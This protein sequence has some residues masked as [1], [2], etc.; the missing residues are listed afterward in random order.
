[1]LPESRCWGFIIANTRADLNPLP[2]LKVNLPRGIHGQRFVCPSL[3]PPIA[4]W[5]RQVCSAKGNFI[6]H[7]TGAPRT[8]SA[9]GRLAHAARSEAQELGSS[10]PPSQLSPRG[11][12]VAVP[13][14]PS[15]YP[16]SAV[17]VSPVAR[18]Q[19]H[20]IRLV[21]EHRDVQGSVVGD[22]I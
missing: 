19:L 4:P 13:R 8:T 5:Q 17:D 6:C 20:H 2:K 12:S 10:S 21:A 7:S 16:V 1:M 18:Q 15:P 11:L 14:Q 3:L 22:W 9:G